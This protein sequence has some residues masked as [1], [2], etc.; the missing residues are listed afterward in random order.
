[1]QLASQGP[2]VA[3]GGVQV[4]SISVGLGNDNVRLVGMRDGTVWATTD[5]SNTLTNV[6]PAGAPAGVTVGKVMVDPNNT[7]PAAITAYIG[8]GGFG[9]AAAPMTHVWKTT[10]L[11]GGAAT[12]VA[13]NNGLP[14]IPIDAIAID[15]QSAVA[16]LAGTSIYLGTD[17]GVYQSTD[18]GSEL[19]DLS[20]LTT[21]CR[22]F[23]FS[24]WLFK[25]RQE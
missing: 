20:I 12:W 3:G 21:H 25:N 13:M 24:T 8:Y 19:G 1:M 2:I 10:N 18:G 9:T 22:C 6:T 11:A 17:I 14:D 16:P 23:R 4:T 5:G 15:R 7:D